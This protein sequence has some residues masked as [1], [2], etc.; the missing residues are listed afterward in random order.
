MGEQEDVTPYYTDD[1]VM[2]FRSAYTV[3]PDG[4]W[5]WLRPTDNG[6]GRFWI[7]GRTA[8]AHRISYEMHVGPIPA[9]LQIDHLCRNRG[10]IN[11]SHLEPVTIAEN[12]LR[13]EGRSAQNARKSTCPKGHAL[14]GDNVYRTPKGGRGCRECL[15]ES[16]RQWRARN[17]K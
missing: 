14:A 17:T 12:V 13:G 6:Y 15:R 10:C 3:M 2:R 4:C 11:P 1:D 5:T 8:L 9:G 16:T 7:K